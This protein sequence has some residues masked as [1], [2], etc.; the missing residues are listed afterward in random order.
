M[1]SLPS[2]YT[3]R[4]H[5]E[6]WNTAF[7]APA[8][9]LKFYCTLAVD[10]LQ[11]CIFCFIYRNTSRRWS[12]IEGRKGNGQVHYFEAIFTAL[13]SLLE[14]LAPVVLSGSLLLL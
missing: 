4:H 12:I 13:S 14:R 11:V 8:L 9:L 6:N 3:F 10:E 5:V 7:R 1:F 2:F